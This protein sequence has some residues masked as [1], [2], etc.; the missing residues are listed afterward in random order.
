MSYSHILVAIDD[1]PIA[2]A[3]AEHAL[4]LARLQNSKVSLV[5]VVAFD[6]FIGVNFYQVAPAVTEHLLQAEQHAQGVLQEL[7][8]TFQRENIEVSSTILRGQDTAHELCQYA[9]QHKVDL[10]VM[11]SHGRKGLEKFFLGSTAQN[12]LSQSKIPVFVI[13]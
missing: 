12:V 3:A 5:S 9:D 2:F 7:A 8:T 4:T 6:P 1:S 11:G 10:I 13:K